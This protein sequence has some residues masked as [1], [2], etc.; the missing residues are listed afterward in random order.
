MNKWNRKLLALALA[1]TMVCGVSLTVACAETTIPTELP[2]NETLYFAGQQWDPV[3]SWNIISDNQNNAMA[4]AGD[5]SR[6][7]LVYETLYMF[8]ILDGKLYPLLADGQP[9]MN[10]AQTEMTIKINSAAKFNDGT[11]VTAKD[12][13]ATYAAHVKY[14]D[15]TGKNL[16]TYIDSIEAVDDAT[17]LIKA[18]L[19]DKG[20]AKNPLELYNQICQLYIT[21]AAWIEKIDKQVNGD[22]DAFKNYTAKDDF[23]ASGPYAGAVFCDE[24][25]LVLARN[26]NYWGQDAS[27]WGKLPA[28]KYIGH[29]FYAD[30][31]AGTVAL[32]A[33]EVDVSQ[34]FN[35]DVQKF[36]LE[37]NLPIST[38]MEEAPYGICLVMPTAWF[39][40]NKPVI[41]DNPAL[42]KAIAMA[43]DYD[44]II[45]NAM[46]NQSPTFAQVPRSLMN[47]TE[48]QQAMYDKEAVKDL[49]WVGKDIEG[50][51]K[52]L[53]EAGIVDTDK[54]GWR[55]IGG[56]KISLNAV[57]PNGWSD[58][59]AAMEIVA[60]AGKDIGIEITTLFPEWSEEQTV[61]TDG[62][63]TQYDI[64]MYSI[65]G[66]GPTFPW[67]TVRQIGSSEYIGQTG[68]WS[69]N[70]GQYKN[71][72][73]DEIIKAI[74]TTTDPEELKALYTEATKIYL[75]EVPS[76]ALMYRPSVFHTVNE[77]VW[78]NYPEEGDEH[79]YPPTDCTD[80]YGIGALY[81]LELVNP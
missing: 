15:S 59:M 1:L 45:A 4:I 22:V 68:N 3:G 63:Q 65:G 42:R 11:P 28:P 24:Q 53:D 55:E 49:Q 72:R 31:A 51:K 13:A 62:N 39:N 66:G 60:A 56:E 79:G 19:D 61:F 27:L 36:W 67:N 20:A 21:S 46:T 38:Y 12:V 69:G 29:V 76:F 77:S 80:G 26:D 70:W 71:D 8:N 33:G 75:T 32:E 48:G 81:D 2:R 34:Q 58:W 78:T 6:R 10:E 14:Q 40:F 41:A 43:V 30:N 54:D 5:A 47:P 64:F 7:V 18:A 23:V 25:K 17:V 73:L 52:L 50:A 74:P 57:C 37:K 35:A 16:P 9:V 44:Q